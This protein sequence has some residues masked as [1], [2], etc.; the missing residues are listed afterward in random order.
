M[1]LI[2]SVAPDKGPTT[3]VC[4]YDALL[5]TLRCVFVDRLGI[6][7]L[8][9]FTLYYFTRGIRTVVVRPTRSNGMIGVKGMYVCSRW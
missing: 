3:L 9:S 5:I 2:T 6:L 1:W 8:I 7:P 4:W